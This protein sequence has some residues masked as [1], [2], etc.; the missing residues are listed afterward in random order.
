[1][2]KSSPIRLKWLYLLVLLVNAAFSQNYSRVDDLVRTYPKSFSSSK[3]LADQ[4]NTDFSS[5]TDKARAIF[6]WI[7]LNIRYDLKAAQSSSG[8]IAYSYTSEQDRQ[9]KEAQ[10]RQRFAEKT[11]RS[12]KGVCQDYS[13]LFHVLCDATGL[14]CIDIAGTS[15]A[16]PANIGKLPQASDHQWNAVRI[17]NQWKLIDVT[18]ASGSVSTET[19]KFVAD[20]N[21]AYFFTEPEVFFLNHFPD[22]KRLLLTDRTAKEF[23]DLPLYYGP[24]IKADYEIAFPEKGIFSKAKSNVIPFRIIDFPSNSQISYVF[25][26]EG[27]V[28]KAQIRNVGNVSEFEIVM[29]DRTRGFLTVFADNAAIATYKIDR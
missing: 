10:F 5:E 3:K 6:T 26:N 15:K 20:F 24:Y 16:H 29:N 12:G 13:S 18:W 27:K 21:D 22:D 23:A 9:Q 17:N 1:M 11:L 14:K 19:G 25:T 2:K 8:V 4:I 28:R 7:G